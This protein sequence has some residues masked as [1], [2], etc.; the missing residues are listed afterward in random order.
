MY[1]MNNTHF[2]RGVQIHNRKTKTSI[3]SVKKI[4]KWL[5]Q[6]RWPD[7][8]LVRFL[9]NPSSYN[10]NDPIW[11]FICGPPTCFTYFSSV[12][13]KVASQVM[14]WYFPIAWRFRPNWSSP[15]LPYL[16]ATD[17]SNRDLLLVHPWMDQT[18]LKQSLCSS[19]CSSRSL[20][21]HWSVAAQ[22]QGKFRSGLHWPDLHPHENK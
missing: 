18:K 16:S 2:F 11:L 19:P 9:S 7:I 22:L 21:V 13:N 6:P 15:Y 5:I 17:H 12:W 1:F 3:H 14:F 20:L 10:G 8:G 4:I